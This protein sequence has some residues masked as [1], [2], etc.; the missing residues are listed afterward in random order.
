MKS[1]KYNFGNICG[2]YVMSN[3]NLFFLCICLNLKFEE[4]KKLNVECLFIIFE[5]FFF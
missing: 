5:I 3:M 2:F 1:E 4:E